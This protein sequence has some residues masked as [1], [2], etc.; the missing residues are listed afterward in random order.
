MLSEF[1]NILVYILC[2]SK[3]RATQKI[4]VLE[5]Q[6]KNMINK[7]VNETNSFIL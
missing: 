7:K 3:A 5:Y 6:K 2:S 4:L 1:K